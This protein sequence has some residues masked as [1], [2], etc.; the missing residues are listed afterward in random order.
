MDNSEVDSLPE[1]IFT[2][3]S[4]DNN[5][6]EKRMKM[7][8]V[9]GKPVQKKVSRTYSL[10]E[11]S[12]REGRIKKNSNDDELLEMSFKECLKMKTFVEIMACLATSEVQNFQNR[13]DSKTKEKN[14]QIKILTLSNEIE[15]L[16]QSVT[17]IKKLL[18]WLISDEDNDDPGAGTT[19]TPDFERKTVYESST[20]DSGGETGA[21]KNDTSEAPYSRKSNSSS[22][23]ERSPYQYH[24]GVAGTQTKHSAQY[25]T[26]YITS[27]PYRQPLSQE[28]RR[29]K[30]LV[31]PFV[32]ENLKKLP[33]KS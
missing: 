1:E 25:S 7:L 33:F 5:M 24:N 27:R 21:V 19:K 23:V 8:K 31:Q 14:T 26:K 6:L 3:L 12:N 28:I 10:V 9:Y 15:L 17:D 11:N 29:D 4:D 30:K 32:E 2:N 16:K 22:K 20:A 13:D 18:E